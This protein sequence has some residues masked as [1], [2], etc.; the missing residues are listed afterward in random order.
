VVHYELEREERKRVEGLVGERE[1]ETTRF[2]VV[3]GLLAEGFSFF[4]AIFSGIVQS[5]PRY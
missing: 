1:R 4:V 3:I 5:L 2:G